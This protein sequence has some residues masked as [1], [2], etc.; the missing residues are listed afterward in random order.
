[1]KKIQLFSKWIICIITL[2]VLQQEVFSQNTCAT[3]DPFCTQTGTT[4]PAGVN[5]G[6]APA[7]PNYGC[8]GTQPNPAWFYLNIATS[9]NI[10]I[11]LSNSANVDIDFII[12]GPFTSQGVMCT[13]IFNQTAGSGIDCSYS[14]AANEQVD[15]PNAVAGQW[16]MLMITNFSNLPTNISAVAGNAPGTDGTTN[17][18]ILSTCTSTAVGTNVSCNGG[19]NG[20][21]LVTASTGSPNFNVSWTGPSSGN[22]GG[23]EMTA[24]GGTYNIT[25][26]VAGSYTVTVTDATGCTSQN[27]VNITQPPVLTATQAHTNPPCFGGTTT[28]TITAT[29]GTAPY[30]VSWTGTTSG[31][32]AGNEIT[33]SG[34]TYNMTGLG[35]GTYNVTVTSAGGCTATVAVVV[36]TPTALVLN[37]TPTAV[38][39]AGGN[40]G[41]ILVTASGSTAPYN[42][43]WTG[44][45]TGNPAGNEIAASGGTYNITGLV[46]GAYTVTLT[47]TGGCTTSAVVNVNPGVTIDANITPVAAQCLTGNSFTFNGTGS[48]IS[49]GS[50]TSYNW[51]F[52]AGATPATGTGATPP[53]VTYSGAGTITVSLT[54]SNGT[55]TNTENLNITINANPTLA[56]TPTNVACNGGSTG[57]IAVTGSGGAGTAPYNVS[58]TGTTSGNPGGNEIAASGG[59]YNMTGLPAGTYNITLTAANGCT[60][61]TT[62]NITQPT[63][64]TAS[65]AETN[66]ACFGGLTGSGLI[67]ATGGTAPYNVSWTGTTSGNPAGNEIAASGGTY[68]MTGL[69]AGTYN[70]TV[71]DANG[72]TATT[73]VNITQPT[74][75]TATDVETNVACFGG[76][77]GS[78]LITATGGTAP[79]N[80]SWTG[81]SSG[82]P[83]GNEIA[84]SGGTYNITG[85]VAGVYTVTV[86]N[87]NGC[88]ATTTVNI[89]QPTAVT[90]SNTFIQPTCNGGTNGSVT[91]TGS[92]G[93]APYNVSWTGTTS[94]NP[95][96]N[97]IAAS[98]GTYTLTALG[99]GTYN[100]TVTDANGC[101]ATTTATVTQPTAV[102]ASDVETNVSC[103]GLTNG[104]GAVT[105]SGGT[106]PYNVSWTGTTTGN[107]AGNEI[108]ASGG[109]YNMT[110]LGVGTYNVTVTDANGCTA[111]TTV[112]ITQPS[113]ITLTPSSTNTNCGSS[114]GTASVVAA[115]GAGGYSYLWSPAPGGGQGT[116]NATGLAA[117]SYTVTVTDANGCT[118]SVNII[119]NANAAPTGSEVMGSHVNVSCFG[120]NNGSGTVQAT[121]GTAPYN[122]SWTGPSTGNPAGNEIAASGGTYA[123]NSLVAGVYTVTI[124]DAGGCTATVNIT[125]TQPA[126]IAIVTAPSPALCFGAAT[127]SANIT[128]SNGTAPY[129]VSWTGPTTGNPAGNEIAASGGSYNITGMSNG[130]YTVTVTDANGCTQT[131]AV[132]IT[133]PTAVTATD[134]ETNVSCNGG[135]NGSGVVTA[136]G[137]TAPYN[138]SWTGTTSGNPAGT[139]IAASG[140]TY[141]LTSLGVGTYN[142]T[143]TDANGC[144]GTTTV[145]ITQPAAI[146]LTPSSTNAN[147]GA[148]DGTASIVAAGG[149]GGFTYNWS[150][151]PGGG[152]GTANATG[153]AATSYTVTVTDANGCTANSVIVVGSNS[154][155]TA[156]EVSHINVACNGGSTGSI[157]VTSTG[158]SPGYNVSWSGAAT[159]NPAGTEIA[160]SGGTYNITGLIAGNYTVTVNDINSCPSTFNVTVTQPAVLTATDVETNVSC[161]GGTN[162]SG[163]ITATGGT[164]PYNVSW[165]GTTTGNPAGNEIAA[166]GGTYAMPGLGV[167]TYNVTVT[168]ANGCTAT[169]TVNIT[170]P[171]AITITGIAVTDAVCNGDCN[172][173]VN[174]AAS[175]GT[176]ALT[177]NWVGIGTG[178]SQTNLC[179]G[180]YNLIVT[181]AN[182]CSASQSATVNEPPL[183]T[184]SVTG[185]NANCGAADGS[186]TVTA[187]GG[188]PV[189]T[190]SWAPA[191]G[192]GQGTANATGLSAGSY[193]VTVTDNKGC[194]ATATVNIGNNPAGT[195]TVATDNNVSCFGANDGQV[196]ATVVGGAAPLTYSWNTTPVQ[197]TATATNLGPGTYT[198]TITDGNG[199]II[200]GTATVTE[201]PLLTITASSTNVTCPAGT[202][203]TVSSGATGGSGAITYSWTGGLPANANNT[204]VS[205]GTYT[206]T[207]T[208]ANGCTASATVTVTVPPAIVINSSVIDVKCNGACDGGINATVSGGTTPYSY[209][210]NDPLIQT[211]AFASNMCVGTY[212]LTVTDGNG[213]VQTGNATVNEPTP[214]SLSTTAVDANCNQND[215]SGCV[216]ASG[217]TPGYVY[218]WPAGQTNSCESNLFAGTYLVIVTDANLCSD[219]AAVQINDI[220]GPSATIIAQTDVSCFGLSDGSA[221]VDMVGG[222]GFFTVQWDAFAANQTTPTASNLAA[223]NYSVVI[224]DA[225]GCT[226]NTSVTINE[227]ADII[228][229]PGST[230]PSCFSYC[231]GVAFLGVLGGT[232]PYTFNWLDGSNNPIGGNNDSI[233]GL[234]QGNYTVNLFDANGCPETVN[235]TLTEPAQVT[236]SIVSTD[237]SCF[238]AC[239]G[240]ADLTVLSGVSPY[241]YSWNDPSSQ[242]T[243]DATNL[244]DGSYTVTITDA[245][246]CF[247][248]VNT[249]ITQPPL[250]TAVI[251]LSGNVSCAGTCDGFAQVAVAG[252]TAPYTVN[253][254]NSVSGM[255]NNNLC[256][257]Q[258]IVTVTDAN[259]CVAIDTVDIIEPSGLNVVMSS[260]N[261]TCYN[262]CNGDGLAT[263]SGGTTPYTYQWDD[264]TFATTS[265]VNNLCNGTYNVVVTDGN[266]CTVSGTIIITEPTILDFSVT[267]TDANC[268][269]N[270]GQICTNVIGGV[271]PYFYSWDDPFLQT[272]PCA[273]NLVAGCYTL[274]LTDGNGCTKDSLLCIN[275]IAG[276]SVGVT[277][278]SDV[279]CFGLNDGTITINASG[280]VGTLSIVW[281]DGTGTPIATLNDQTSSTTLDGDNYAII[282]T[283]SAGCVATTTQFIAEPNA[284]IAA[285]TAQTQ[286]NC[287]GGCDATA[288]VSSSGGV[289]GNTILWSAGSATTSATNTGLCAGPVSVT[290]TDA[291]GCP[292]SANTV[293]TQPTALSMVTNAVTNVTCNGNCDGTITVT[294]SGAT[295]PYTF[296]WTGNVSTGTLATNLCP[297]NYTTTVTDANGCTFSVSNTITEPALLTAS[298][299]VTDATCSQCNGG[300]TVTALGGTAPYSYSWI[301]GN[302]IT[303]S[304]NTGLCTGTHNVTV[305]DANGCTVVANAVI[306]DQ[307]GP[308]INNITFTQ[309]SCSGLS[310]GTATVNT[311]GGTG[312]LTYLWTN[313]QVVPTAVALPAGNYCVTVTDQN[314]CVANSCVN[315]T[316]PTP[317]NAIGDLDATICFGDSTQVWASGA[318]GTA[319]YTINWS[320]AGMSGAGPIMVTPATTTSYCFTV[321][322]ANG[323]QSPNECVL[324]TVNPPLDI[325]LTPSTSICDGSSINLVANATGGNGGPYTFG[326][327]DENGNNLSAT[328]VSPSSNVTVNPTTPTWYYVVV[329]DGCSLPAIDSTQITIDNNPIVFL[330]VVDSNGCAPFTAQ[331]IVNTDIG[332]NFDFDFDCDGN[333][334]YSGTTPNATYTYPNTTQSPILYDVCLTVTSA[335]GCTTLV[336]EPDF[337]EVY[338]VPVA[339]FTATPTVTTILNPEILFTDL[340]VGGTI[341]D[342]DFGD[343][344]SSVTVGDETHFYQDSGYYNVTLAIEN[345]YGCTSQY[346]LPVE[347]LSDF[348]IYVPNAFT[349][350]GD[351][352]N[353]FFFPEG[354]GI[355]PN[356]FEFMVFNRWGELIYQTENVNKPWDGTHKGQKSKQDVYVWKVK[357]FDSF[358]NQ[359]DYIGHVTL[360]R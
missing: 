316:Q 143:V 64:L 46:A 216:I 68:N 227:P 337:V 8:L 221:T 161:N 166:S 360:L 16:Y 26:L 50:I 29:G 273:F 73:T 158:G 248:T 282:V 266:G 114:T 269:Q 163:V 245:D 203:G 241:T 219:T 168:D 300:S 333:V 225:V 325:D 144:T 25:G 51:N 261:A 228:I 270:N 47:A 288:T 137:G 104:N 3:A 256:Q 62:V 134:V 17:C 15:I 280:G 199:C 99:A 207:A 197:T 260:N 101:T 152:Q 119:V 351:G 251:N 294:A 164:A 148:S 217:G 112:N 341:Y 32:P 133:Q 116:A 174:A 55:C 57:A 21:I 194:I 204:N 247:N 352:Q 27:V 301:T 45:S 209:V 299:T 155:P 255:I 231:D 283:D 22:P 67:T 305:T 37:T 232:Q 289:G 359:H 290:V 98:G 308:V 185:T 89:T 162:G 31:N 107:P 30:N 54:V 250:L 83:A 281:E 192:G 309:P 239:D 135:T 40:N 222:T 202:N 80:V 103:N 87:A 240:G 177:Y 254:S 171:T 314:G 76:S 146:T 191:P 44:P 82:N 71:T 94:G 102:T 2:L 322:D 23:S 206:V 159:G 157:L 52:G 5:N 318:G 188:T 154:A 142:V 315:V 313:G 48:T 140:G 132:N 180:T 173:M 335:A 193:T 236:G 109:T 345:Q 312:A 122:V 346:T 267:P 304:T 330:N 320:T 128:V 205:A 28:A 279:S 200:S 263:V 153:L 274:T 264:P 230:D 214:L 233:T 286:P 262:L 358:G 353:D 79:Y 249:T 61:T 213:C 145:N 344:D 324:I 10:Q 276:P 167:G 321:T 170:Q 84:A 348:A 278:F 110:G 12:W 215:G 131:A 298:T 106:A 208:D 357:A 303:S 334:D 332:T 156:S 118:A 129:N 224:T 187:G 120:G 20:S 9:G 252:G 93:T 33:V 327:T 295:T 201:P 272:T 339:S 69:G 311:T 90:A 39:C 176:G 229:N 105:A 329:N 150:P 317:L 350:N 349:P 296:T 244:C 141:T 246:G 169:T 179:A 291:N 292:A 97:E 59:T 18:S 34:G 75:T 235:Y 302:N 347:I 115:G 124:T 243:Q 108:A 65:D 183:L 70:V 198:V 354:I 355:D 130:A 100:I 138:V 126:A 310:N 78:G 125:I 184:A 60:A 265:A 95:A 196:S 66:V 259:G 190:Y 277:S 271:A 53:A 328:T 41:S 92:G 331:F 13:Q 218:Q 284:M 42:V 123:I 356:N 139:E 285:I 151:A 7:G 182:N 175:G 49:S 24:T 223:G 4:Y 113:A 181:D 211:T 19:N 319:P 35:A 96:G 220:A 237:V 342:W 293:I 242:T 160:A 147:C 91:V 63:A 297:G 43:S 323:C 6:T 14:T 257:G 306:I 58:W 287:F 1:M 258:Y 77:T 253:W 136:S 36:T 149:A 336:S 186:A 86:T 127:G 234:C 212:T 88:T 178:A 189:Y 275:D 326:W 38:S 226:A 210:W 238:N 338:P 343:G 11:N 165:T 72:C 85:L 81:P 340:S 268:G 121:G 307:A 111:T 117:T 56:T 74:G 172:G 195:V